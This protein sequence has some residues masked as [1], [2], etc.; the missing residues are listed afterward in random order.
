MNIEM[1][2]WQSNRRCCLFGPRRAAF[3]NGNNTLCTAWILGIRIPSSDIQMQSTNQPCIHILYTLQIVTNVQS[4]LADSDTDAVTPWTYS[5]RTSTKGGGTLAEVQSTSWQRFLYAPVTQRR[6]QLISIPQESIDSWSLCNA[7]N[8]ALG[9]EFK[10]TL[11]D[12][13]FSSYLNLFDMSKVW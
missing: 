6:H 3:T 2:D 12:V 4:L 5:C 8:L 1:W 13:L 7:W 9:A 10:S 11:I